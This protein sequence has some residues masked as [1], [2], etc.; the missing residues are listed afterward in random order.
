M[1]C[2]AV[3]HLPAPVRG[4]FPLL[5]RRAAGKPDTQ[6]GT[7]GQFSTAPGS[8]VEISCVPPLKTAHRA[9][10]GRD[11]PPIQPNTGRMMVSPMGPPCQRPSLP[12]PCRFPRHTTCLT[13]HL[14]AKQTPEEADCSS[15][16]CFIQT[17]SGPGRLLRTVYTGRSPTSRSSALW[18]HPLHPADPAPGRRRNLPGPQ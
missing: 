9:F 7:P 1:V 5:R 17:R 10:S 4:I 8:L 2:P 14:I 18:Y 13:I 3:F 15:G 11:I 16:V 12:S 6:Q